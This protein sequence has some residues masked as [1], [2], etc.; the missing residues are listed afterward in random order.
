MIMKPCWSEPTA[1][2]PMFRPASRGR[3]NIF[4]SDAVNYFLARTGLSLKIRFHQAVG[5]GCAL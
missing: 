4:W 1:V 2:L 5:S 3:R